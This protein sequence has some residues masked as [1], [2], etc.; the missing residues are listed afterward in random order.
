MT[1]SN[2]MTEA[3]RER[4]VQVMVSRV[5]QRAEADVPGAAGTTRE[6][7]LQQRVKVWQRVAELFASDVIDAL[8]DVS[9]GYA[10]WAPLHPVLSKDA[11]R[12]M[13]AKP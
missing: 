4:L 1:R 2:A 11:R 3:E 13:E 9:P 5:L 10:R 12:A 8:S 7:Q 6:A